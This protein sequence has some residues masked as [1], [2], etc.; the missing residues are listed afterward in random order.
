MF[1]LLI[2]LPELSDQRSEN[3]RL[4]TELAA[5]QKTAGD[6]L[7]RLDNVKQ[8]SRKSIESTSHKYA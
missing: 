4:R 1:S 8:M 6:T 5:S 2:R 7:S 3:E